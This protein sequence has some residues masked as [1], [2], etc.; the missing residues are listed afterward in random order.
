MCAFNST[1]VI[2]TMVLYGCVVSSFMIGTK[3]L[4]ACTEVL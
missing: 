3:A 1:K 4:N 2:L